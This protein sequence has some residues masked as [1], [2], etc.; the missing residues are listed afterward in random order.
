[1][2]TLE[3]QTSAAPM[4]RV[5]AR[6]IAFGHDLQRID[7]QVGNSIL[8]VLDALKVREIAG[9]QFFVAVNEVPVHPDYWGITFPAHNDR[10][11]INIM[12]NGGGGKGGGKDIKGILTV[13]AFQAVFSTVGFL[14][15]GPAGASA[16]ASLGATVGRAVADAQSNI[17]PPAP[18]SLD[19][20]SGSNPK[21]SPSLYINGTKNRANQYGVICR[22]YGRNRLVPSYGAQPYTELVG[23]DMYLRLL[24]VVSLG[25]QSLS[26]LRI[27]Q[28]SIDDFDDVQIEFN[29]GFGND[30]THK[31]YPKSVDV[32]SFSIH[33]KE[34][35]DPVVRTSG[36]GAD[37]I[38]ILLE[39][40][41][42]IF[43]LDGKTGKQSKSEV[44]VKVETRETGSGDGWKK[45]YNST[46]SANTR[47]AVRK[48]ITWKPKTRGQYD[49]RITRQTK[50]AD[51]NPGTG[52][53]KVSNDMY[54]TKVQTFTH[55]P[56]LALTDCCSIAMRIKATDQLNGEIDAVNLIAYSL[57]VVEEKSFD[58]KFN[59]DSI[60]KGDDRKFLPNNA[61]ARTI[62]AWFRS[63]STGED[64]QG[65]LWTAG[66][67]GQER[68]EDF[69]F[70]IKSSAGT[71]VWRLEF[72]GFHIDVTLTD[73]LDNNWHHVAVVYDP[74]GPNTARVVYDG[75][76]VYNGTLAHSIDTDLTRFIVGAWRQGGS[77][78]GHRDWNFNGRIR[79][80]R[81]WSIARS[82]VDIAADKDSVL[83][84]SESGLAAWFPCSEGRGGVLYDLSGN[85]NHLY[86][87]GNYTWHND[88]TRDPVTQLRFSQ[89]PAYI[90]K[91]ILT[92]TANKNP[93]GTERLDTTSLDEWKSFCDTNDLSFNLPIDF[94]TTVFELLRMV[95]ASGRASFAQHD[96]LYG[97]VIDQP[98]TTPVQHFTPR[99]SRAFKCTKA[100]ADMPH[101]V[102]VRFVNEE[103]SYSQ[104]QMI[105]YDD[106]YNA[107]GTG[108]NTAATQF[109][110]LELAGV[111]D[112]DQ[113]WKLA[114]YHIAVARLRPRI[115]EIETD[116]EFIICQ[117]GDMVR[118]TH[119]VALIGNG[120]GRITGIGYNS[121][122]DVIGF[123]TDQE[124]TMEDGKSYVA[125]FRTRAGAFIDLHLLT[126][127]GTRQSFLFDDE[128]AAD[129]AINEGDLVSFGE[130]LDDESHGF[131]EFVVRSITPRDDMSAIITLVD[132]SPAI[133][134]ADTGEIPPF[135]S[136][137]TIPPDIQFGPSLPRILTA[138]SDESALRFESDGS[139]VVQVIL[140]YTFDTPGR[141]PVDRIE[142][143][144]RLYS[145]DDQPWTVSAPQPVQAGRTFVLVGPQ[146]GKN[147]NIELRS[148]GR[149]G[150][151]SAWSSAYGHFIVGQSTPPPA[152][153][154]ISVVATA[155]GA[156]EVTWD[157]PEKLPVDLDGVQIR[158]GRGHGVAWDAM[159]ALHKSVLRAGPLITT[160]IPMGEITLG[161]KSVDL[162]GNTSGAYTENFTFDL[163]NGPQFFINE[164][165]RAHG[166]P[167]W[168]VDNPNLIL[169]EDG[170]LEA[171]TEGGWDDLTTWDSAP[172]W[173]T[174]TIVAGPVI[175][176]DAP[177]IDLGTSTRFRVE[178]FLSGY[179]NMKLIISA[180][181]YP[182]YVKDT[183]A[184][185]IVTSTYA[186]GQVITFTAV[187]NSDGF[188]GTANL[189]RIDE[190]SYTIH[191]TPLEES[192][193]ALDTSVGAIGTGEFRLSITRDFKVI[194]SVLINFV[195]GGSGWTY[196]VLDYD[197]D[198]GP[199]IKIYKDGTLTHATINA[200]VR[201]L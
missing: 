4:F 145:L 44:K 156:R 2:Q 109:E 35:N 41:K 34:E 198:D 65:G 126:D 112:P 192:I 121:A 179:G 73:S 55:E 78:G 142:A 67:S 189:I 8:D 19:E 54:W 5:F 76:E 157:F 167:D 117:R 26:D 144:Y 184:P 87:G 177:A 77:N 132:K 57:F 23:N 147:Y 183:T 30:K 186:E 154:D 127:A 110:T 119:D 161:I 146:Q 175:V 130:W 201:G 36:T 25:P 89:N 93:L 152:P 96:S 136:N 137:V 125:H 174:G 153:T 199:H 101:A 181:G 24:F 88:S 80:V 197:V 52:K 133:Y 106:G 123:R 63:N 45:V 194:D 170:S 58:L 62:E 81:V 176:Y 6:C 47:E 102:K 155:T 134:T 128:D 40:P 129:A 82:T 17:A 42:G 48:A 139:I 50:D 98:D 28:T 143:R 163:S 113:I 195:G 180:D 111:T 53:D 74:D 118:L 32:Q 60:A 92:G 193:V 14:I 85:A 138:V 188:S 122:G 190:L 91:D 141:D 99:N 46:I 83:T 162:S 165:L 100:F 160:N 51:P 72:W 15:A 120:S 168:E 37:E 182:F 29:Y 7:C 59:G 150:S 61:E 79:D 31:L 39:F 108:G 191:N 173:S 107:D 86:L 33:V 27:G 151:V 200:V 172:S 196:E 103:Q 70:Y 18:P 164:N 49:I 21:S 66:I 38:N 131:S 171:Q 1:M 69:S 116:I 105:I 104:D 56:P 158:F 95:C 43:V 185:S 94:P 64:G 148:I 71:D 135:D 124:V 22:N 115:I 166:W 9:L 13:M 20:L 159:F 75:T 97:V 11:L 84:G 149:N 3:Q 10:L 178:A 12:P 90:F 68:G 187:S 114:R 16:G 140:T 169:N